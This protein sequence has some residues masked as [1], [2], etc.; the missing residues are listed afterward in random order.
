LPAERRSKP[1]LTFLLLHTTTTTIS[2]TSFSK[3]GAA[4]ALIA[5]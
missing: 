4:E 2:K 5:V 1:V 3:G